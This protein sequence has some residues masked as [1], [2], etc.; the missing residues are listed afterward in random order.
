MTNWRPSGRIEWL[1]RRARVQQRIRDFFA[2]RSVTEVST[3]LITPAGVTEPH[4][5]SLSIAGVPGYLRTSP[6]YFH[7][8]LLASGFGD[9]YELGPV[10]RAGEHGRE[11]RTEFT[12]LE[13]YR[14]G[15]DWQQLADETVDLVIACDRRRKPAWRVQRIAWRQLFIQIL[16]FDP[17]EAPDRTIQAATP[18]LPAA[19]D[20]Q[21]RL[22]YLL[23]TQIQ[24]GFSADQLTVV[25]HFPAEQAALAQLDPEDP[26]LALRFEIYAGRIELANGYQELTD[27]VEQGQRFEQ[28]NAVRRSRGQPPM[29]VDEGLLAALS[30]GLPACSGVALGIDRLMMALLAADDLSEVVTFA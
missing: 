22:D 19:C 25:H 16:D 12:M 21:M 24:S 10:L 18:D 15:M 30:H 14:L 29:P 27:P 8:R 28:D 5:E 2:D 3:P 1:H 23:G 11:H 4:I 20:R 26:R 6:E 7:K 9:L 13:W 17:L